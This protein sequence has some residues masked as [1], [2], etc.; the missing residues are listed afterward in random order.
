VTDETLTDDQLAQQLMSA[1]LVTQADLIKA[2]HT[3]RT[4]G[5]KLGRIL[6][7][8]GVVTE[9]DLLSLQEGPLVC[10]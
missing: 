1:G 8:N 10:R 6:V 2:R 4:Q 3:L 9:D 5:G 7:A